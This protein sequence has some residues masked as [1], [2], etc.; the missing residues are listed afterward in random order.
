MTV[1]QAAQDLLDALESLFTNDFGGYQCNKDEALDIDGARS[2]L[3]QALKQP[4]RE[5]V[6]LTRR[7]I[8]AMEFPLD[9][10]VVDLAWAIETKLREK[11]T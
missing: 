2:A 6:E 10:S 4:P 1:E 3:E 7:E 11:N 9:A 5:W 8:V